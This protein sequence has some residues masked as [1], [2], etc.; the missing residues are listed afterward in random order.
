MPTI[1]IL[2]YDRNL[3]KKTILSKLSSFKSKQEWFEVKLSKFDAEE[4]VAIYYFYQDVEQQ[5]KSL[6]NGDE[7]VIFFLKQKNKTKVLRKVYCFFNLK[8]KTLEVYRGGDEIFERIVE[9]LER[10]LRIKLKKLEIDSNMLLKLIKNSNEL[11]QSFFKNVNGYFLQMFKSS[12][13]QQKKDFWQFLV[14]NKNC[15]I[16]ITIRP[17]I[18]LISNS[19]YAVTVNSSNSTLKFS[20]SNDFKFRPR[21]EVRQIVKMLASLG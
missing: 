11:I 20:K 3:D 13:L 7:E 1:T 21:Y 17:R 8:N 12:N 6:F 9:V 16:A 14:K 19:S 2:R 15:L 18:K 5:I 10:I 4:V